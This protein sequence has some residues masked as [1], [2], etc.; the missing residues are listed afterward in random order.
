MVFDVY[1]GQLD[2]FAEVAWPQLETKI[3]IVPVIFGAAEDR[4]K[5]MTLPEFLVVSDFGEV[6][7]KHVSN[8]ETGDYK[9]A[10]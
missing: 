9:C 10:V 6:N 7:D 1:D 8:D 5:E 4:Q 3:E 2:P